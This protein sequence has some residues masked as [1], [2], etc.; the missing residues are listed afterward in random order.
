MAIILKILWGPID[1]QGGGGLV[2]TSG[3]PYPVATG[4][5]VSVYGYY[6]YDINMTIQYYNY[7]T[8]I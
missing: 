7:D 4:L 2:P 5:I 3:A 8:I 1:Y 6:I